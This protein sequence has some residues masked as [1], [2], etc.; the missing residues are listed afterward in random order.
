MRNVVITGVGIKSCIGNTYQE[1][2]DSLKNGKSGITANETYKEMGFRSQ[3]SGN[4]DLNFAELIDRKLFRFMGE[5]SAYAYLAAQ[6]AIEMAGISEDH[7]NSEK[8]G[9]VAGSGGSSTRVMVSTADITRE[10]GP[11]RIGP[12]AVTKSMGSSISAILGTAYKLKGINYSISSACATSAHCIGHGADLIKSGQQDIVI[13]GGGEDLH[14]SSSNLFDAMGALSSNFN[15]NPSSASRAYDKNRDGFVISGGSGMVIL[16]EE[17]HA[18]KRNANI[19]AKLTGY[20]ATSDGYDMVAPS[21][22]GALRCMKGA[23]QNHGSEVDYIN[24]HGTSTPVGDV[25]ELKAIKELFKNDIPVISSTKSM[26]GHSLGATGVQE[27]I[28]SIMMLKEK[29]IA[30]SINID[31]LCDEAEGLNIATET[32]EKDVNSVLS[33]SFGFGGTN[34]SLVISNYK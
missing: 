21:G 8:T 16:E 4:V 15:D 34:A 25:A 12:Y 5:A 11:K 2:L 24:T 27:A 13:A 1:V 29:F 18:K 14:W 9:I 22:E 28:Y 32:I 20:Y 10:K 3:V 30:P 19:L 23:M 17:E 7:L 6:D 31:E 26:T 33:N